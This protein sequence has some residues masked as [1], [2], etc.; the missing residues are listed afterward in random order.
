MD[1]SQAAD[2]LMDDDSDFDDINVDSD[3]EIVEPEEEE[4]DMN[5]DDDEDSESD[6]DANSTGAA[7]ATPST[8]PAQL[9]ARRQGYVWHSTIRP[10]RQNTFTGTPGPTNQLDVSDVESPYE[11]FKHVFND[12]LFDLL[13][14]E[15]NRYAGQYIAR[16]VL[17]PNSRAKKWKPVTRE[18]MQKFLGLVLL[19][20]I[21]H[22]KGGLSTYWSTDPLIATPFFGSCMPRDR[23]QSITSFLH[24]NNNDELS[25]F[26]D[27]RLYKIRPIYEFIVK[28]WRELYALGEEISI[29]EG[30]L[31]WRRR[32]FFT[33]YNK[34]KP[35]KYGIKSYML[36][37]LKHTIVGI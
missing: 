27:D 8:G 24:F 36:Q 34:D 1:T 28:K 30:M 37:I 18:E 23:F 31:K 15:T 19:T 25:D 12:V 14:E 7:N 16:S 29:D 5:I 10:P 4:S 13:V 35:V 21:L 26:P 20:G 11:Y 32:L 22:K 3:E 33:V 17:L 2:I 9:R 6:E